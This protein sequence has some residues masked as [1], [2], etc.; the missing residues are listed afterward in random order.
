MSHSRRTVT[1]SSPI[2]DFFRHPV[3]EVRVSDA[4]EVADLKAEVERLK[5]IA[6]RAE[7]LYGQ[8]V[9]RTLRYEDFLKKQGYALKDVIR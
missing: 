2:E 9:T 7:F 3:I 8:E 6:N 1:I 5:M 4:K